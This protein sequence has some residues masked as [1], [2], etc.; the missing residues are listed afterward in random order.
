MRAGEQNSAGQDLVSAQPTPAPS[1]EIRRAADQVEPGAPTRTRRWWIAAC[2]IAGAIALFAFLVRIS[3]S[4]PID[5]DGANSALQAWDLLHGN[6]LLHGWIIGDATYYTFELPL[7][8]II[9]YVLGLH[10]LVIHVGSA[11]T[12]V[13]VAACAVA[14][15]IRNSRGTAVAVRSLVVIAILAAPLLTLAGVSIAMEKPDHTG[16]AAIT[17]VCFLLIDRALG[18]R[19][20]APLLCVILCAG[21]LGDATVLYVTVPAIV[22][23]CVYRAI[24]ARTS[25]S[26]DVAMIVAAVVSVPLELLIRAVL[27]QLGGYL[28]ISP[29]IGLAPLRAWPHHA[30]LVLRAIGIL[31]GVSLA[32]Q[33]VL[34]I[35]GCAFGLA[36]LLAVLFGFVRVIWNWRNASRGEQ[37]VC[38]A[39][40]INVAAYMFSTL[41]VASNA[42][43]LIA[44]VPFGAVLA[45]RACVP[46]RIA[47]VPRARLALAG[48]GLAALLPLAASATVP[49]ATPVAAPV[50]AWLEAHG[51]KYGIAGYWDASTVSVQSGDRVR[52]RAVLVT[53]HAGPGRIAANDW[54]T[55]ADWYFPRLHHAMFVIADYKHSWPGHNITPATFEKYLGPPTSVHWVAGRIILIYRRNLLWDVQPAL[56]LWNAKTPARLMPRMP[57]VP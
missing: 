47:S 5:A 53:H 9:E 7:Y 20:A 12:Y 35:V 4:Y 36:C 15:A 1:S 13:I 48:A 49:V 37:L 51:L 26:G 10:G 24:A 6:V 38:V 50:A 31:F 32:R 43:E 46:E 29:H 18:R 57:T 39:I 27:K 54:E 33:S 56:P 14:M 16:T 45:A 3:R 17:L 19:F 11:I 8:A 22:V 44:L 34:G 41:P 25:H 2:W 21:Q 28:M 52:V 42:R 40:V 30:M 55:K 23:V